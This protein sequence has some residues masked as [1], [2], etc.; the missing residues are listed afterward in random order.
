MTE[1]IERV[2]SGQLDPVNSEWV[3]TGFDGV[4]PGYFPYVAEYGDMVMNDFIDP[5]FYA[6][7]QNGEVFSNPCTYTVSKFNTIDSGAE[8]YS[9]WYLSNPN[10]KRNWIKGNVSYYLTKRSNLVYS[11]DSVCQAPAIG[12]DYEQ[13][14][15]QNC[16]AHV[17]STP[18]EFFEDLAEISETIK[19][20]RNPIQGLA[21]LA[22]FYKRRKEKILDSF[23]KK[24]IDRQ[25]EAKALADLWNQY[26]FAA[27]PL[28]RSIM[29]LT[30]VLWGQSQ[31]ERPARRT[32]HGFSDGHESTVTENM[33][34]WAGLP[35]LIVLLERKSKRMVDSHASIYY[36]VSNPLVD[37]QFK[38]GLRLKDV[39]KTMWEVFPLSFMVDRLVNVKNAIIGLLNLSDPSVSFLASS[40]TTRTTETVDWTVTGS[41]YETTYG[42]S[43]AFPGSY[44]FTEFEYKRVNWEPSWR[45]T[46]PVVTPGG[47]VKDLTSILDLISITISRTL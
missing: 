16:L 13:H 23:R 3:I 5:G 39:P 9:V 35:R 2:R 15:K 17:D 43:L 37:W 10:Q 38:L 33:Q 1:P 31:I 12:F 40:F 8:A 19:F 24:L 7:R 11:W 47:L 41:W 30:E 36:E 42:S 6:R 44:R 29:S 46:V 27:A 14:A 22:R 26:R 20:L 34:R 28:V 18:Y 25:Q 32:A 21:D 4:T 45:D